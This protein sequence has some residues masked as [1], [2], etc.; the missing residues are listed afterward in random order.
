MSSLKST[1]T[2]SANGPLTPSPDN[3]SEKFASYLEDFEDN[4]AEPARAKSAGQKPKDLIKKKSKRKIRKA[5]GDLKIYSD[6]DKV[7][8]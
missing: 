2:Q 6:V 4:S 1:G 5:L 7:L 3:S 8:R